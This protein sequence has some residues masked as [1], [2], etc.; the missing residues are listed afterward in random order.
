[1]LCNPGGG[2]L[3][4]RTFSAPTPVSLIPVPYAGFSFAGWIGAGCG[5][6]MTVSGNMTCTA[7]FNRN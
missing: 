4:S 2:S 5:N 6:S 3:C 7:D 1:M